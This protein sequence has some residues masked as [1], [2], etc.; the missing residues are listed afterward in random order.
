M[1]HHVAARCL[2]SHRSSFRAYMWRHTIQ[3][4]LYVQFSARTVF[5]V[6]SLP[7]QHTRIT[8]NRARNNSVWT[9]GNLW[10]ALYK[11]LTTINDGKFLRWP[12]GS[13]YFKEVSW[14]PAH[15][16]NGLILGFQS[17]LS[18]NKAVASVQLKGPPHN[19]SGSHISDLILWLRGEGL[20]KI[21]LL[22]QF[23]Q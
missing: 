2:F 10:D 6:L 21:T 7:V 18:K 22:F 11:L 4:F 3:L 23:L 19:H 5:P 8:A 16:L 20:S 15:A 17:L 1:V 13:R 12:C 9:K 14:N